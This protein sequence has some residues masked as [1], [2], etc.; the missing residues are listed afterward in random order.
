MYSKTRFYR[1]VESIIKKFL[2]F[3]NNSKN[4]NLHRTIRSAIY[5]TSKNRSTLFSNNNNVKLLLHNNDIVSKTLFIDQE[6]DFKVLKKGIKLLGKKESR[7]TLVNVGAHIG[8]SCIPAIK[9]NYFKNLIVFEPVKRNFRLLTA[10]ILL[11]KIEDRTKI[12]NLAL[13]NKKKN[14]YMKMFTNSG[15]C[16]ILKKKQPNCELV[17]SDILDNYTAN[18]NKNNSLIFMDAQGHEPKIFLG[19]QKTIRKK[20]PFIF[21]LIPELYNKTWLK[22]F[23]QLFKNYSYFFDL[24]NTKKTK[25]NAINL[26]KLFNS[27]RLNNDYTDIMI[28]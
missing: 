3:K 27:Y 21:E 17:K 10:N 2:T 26:S 16:R 15:D 14:L 19:A 7:L 4:I 12:Y 9:N 20:I 22:D 8:S 1:I 6:F 18:L 25:F 28:I 23:S 24:K 11:N 5:N 13:S